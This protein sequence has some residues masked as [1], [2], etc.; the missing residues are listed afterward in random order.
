MSELVVF[1]SL[2]KNIDM[3]TSSH[4]HTDHFDAETLG[5]IFENNPYAK[6]IIPEANRAF[7]VDRLKCKIDF[8]LGLK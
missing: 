5:A 4:N 8:P 7:V 3:V 6:F 1:P 2:L